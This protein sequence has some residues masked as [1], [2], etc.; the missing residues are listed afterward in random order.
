VNIDVIEIKDNQLLR[1]KEVRFKIEHLGMPS[2]NRIDVKEKLAAMYTAKPELT[3]IKVM[4]PVF[5]LPQVI[6][7]AHLYSDAALAEK[8]EPHFIRIRNMAK[9]QRNDA[10]KKIREGRKK[11]KKK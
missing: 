3:F 6:G 2:P 5:G 9:D 7:K 8:L 1:R 4:T 10:W 11:K